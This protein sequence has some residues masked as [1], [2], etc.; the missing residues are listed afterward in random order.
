VQRAKFKI[1]YTFPIVQGA[2]F[3]IPCKFEQIFKLSG[4]IMTTFK[5]FILKIN[6][7]NM[8]FI[9]LNLLGRKC[10]RQGE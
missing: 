3:K 9:I 10:P 7:S 6:T 2:K 5:L 1:P 4:K 8:V